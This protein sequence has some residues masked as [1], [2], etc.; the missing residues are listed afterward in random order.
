[1]ELHHPLFAEFPEH[2]QAILKKRSEDAAF[3]RLFE[4]YHRIDDQICRIEEDLEKA[5]FEE[6]ESLKMRRVAVKDDLFHQL[7]LCNHPRVSV[8]VAA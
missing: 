7:W 1:M 3:R 4:E 8:A 5:S 6:L 2:R